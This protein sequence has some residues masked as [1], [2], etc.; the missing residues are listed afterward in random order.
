M[1]HIWS[2]PSFLVVWE[3]QTQGLETFLQNYP[4]V[5][6]SAMPRGQE[7]SF[8]CPWWHFLTARSCPSCRKHLQ[9]GREPLHCFPWNSFVLNLLNFLLIQNRLPSYPGTHCSI[10]LL[11]WPKE[12]IL[13]FKLVVYVAL[14]PKVLEPACEPR[15]SF[16]QL[17]EEQGWLPVHHY[18]GLCFPKCGKEMAGGAG[19]RR[20]VC[21]AA[22]RRSL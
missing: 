5:S 8:L 14:S 11:F 3:G 10:R 22:W 9:W 6:G 15:A 12:N 16:S 2:L 1:R 7:W 4:S 13:V 21:W 20:A 19:E 18:L 17:C